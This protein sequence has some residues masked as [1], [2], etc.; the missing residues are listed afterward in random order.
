[1]KYSEMTPAQKKAADKIRSAYPTDERVSAVNEKRMAAAG[2]IA[3]LYVIVRI[4]YVGFRGELALPELVLLFLMVFV[5]WGI[6]LQNSVHEL[7][8]FF[9]KELDPAP[10]AR[11]KRF[12]IYLAS[13]AFLAGSWTA[14]D[15]FSGLIERENKLAGAA[16]DFGIGLVICLLLTAFCGER[17]VKGYNRYQQQLEAEEN[18]LS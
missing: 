18:D 10:S 14:V 15:Y 13:S 5:M 7:P 4:I 9:G 2:A 1:M 3:I 16:V 11:A 6:D 17:K 8:K 12:L